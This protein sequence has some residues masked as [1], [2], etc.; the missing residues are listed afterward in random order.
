MTADMISNKKLSQIVTELF[1]RG[2]KLNV[3]LVF[4]TQSY[5]LVSVDVRLNNT[6]LLVKSFIKLRITIHLKLTSKTLKS[7]AEIYYR[8]THHFGH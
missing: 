5:I 6:H 2:R 7:S 8:T 3:S 4:I 1:I